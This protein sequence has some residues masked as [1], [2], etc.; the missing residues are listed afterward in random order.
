MGE[1][2][3]DKSQSLQIG[4][5]RSFKQKPEELGW[6][7]GI[8]R[9]KERCRHQLDLCMFHN[10]APVLRRRSSEQPGVAG[11][12]KGLPDWT[13]WVSISY[14]PIICNF[15]APPKKKT[16][17]GNHVMESDHILGFVQKREILGKKCSDPETFLIQHDIYIHIH[18]YNLLLLSF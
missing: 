17:P 10:T 16:G 13:I 14:F 2:N 5:G 6:G 4:W 12:E 1:Y 3:I 9:G 8:I 15:L 11:K 18:I 7:R